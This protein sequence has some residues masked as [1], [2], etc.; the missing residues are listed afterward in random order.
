MKVSMRALQ[1]M[2]YSS[3]EMEE[4]QITILGQDRISTSLINLAAMVGV[5]RKLTKEKYL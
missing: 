3:R 1:K 5:S 2:R 4:L